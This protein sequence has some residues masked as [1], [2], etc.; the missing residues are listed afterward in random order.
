MKDKIISIWIG[1]TY[2]LLFIII[3]LLS[4]Y[5]NMKILYIFTAIMAVIGIWLSA[6]EIEN[7]IAKALKKEAKK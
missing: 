6:N 1:I 4:K 7:K 3:I 2:S 5:V